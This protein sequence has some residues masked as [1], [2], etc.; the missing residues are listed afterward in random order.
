MATSTAKSVAEYLRELPAERAEA[1]QRVRE[2]ILGNLPEGYEEG[3]QY[4]MIGYYVPLERYPDTYNGQPLG[5]AALASQKNYMSVYLHGVYSD[6]EVESWFRDAYAKSGKKLDMGKSCV[7]FR[8]IDD[9]PLKVIGDT[10]A[11]VPVDAFLRRYELS[12]R[13]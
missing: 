4:G 11:R 10:I 9:L 5:V 7:R 13:R 8:R 12:R 1:I 6:P 3:M 2:V